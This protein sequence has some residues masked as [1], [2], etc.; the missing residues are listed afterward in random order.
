MDTDAIYA[1]LATGSRYGW[2]RM[3]CDGWQFSD[4]TAPEPMLGPHGRF[5]VLMVRNV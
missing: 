1:R 4:T 3:L 5:A 2:L